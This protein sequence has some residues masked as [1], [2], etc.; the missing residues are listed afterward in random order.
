MSKIVKLYIFIFVL[1]VVAMLYGE[2]VKKKTINWFPSY[3]KKHKIPYGTYVLYHSLKD[4]FPDTKIKNISQTPYLFLKEEEQTG[5]YLFIDVGINIDKETQYKLLD[6]VERGNSVFFSTRGFIIDTLGIKTKTIRP[7]G[8]DDT[9]FFKLYSPSFK[10]KEYT[11]DR[12]FSNIVFSKIDTLKTTI[13]GQSGY[14][15]EKGERS[16]SGANFIKHQHGNGYFYFHT[17]PE[18]FTNY[19]ILNSP[20]HLYAAGVLSYLD[21]PKILFWDMYYKTGKSQISSPMHY[22]LT[23]KP[24]KWAYYIM[25]FGVLIYILFEGK[26]KQRSIPIITPLKNQ[27]LAFTRTI[28]NMYFE[29]QENKTIAE[30][31]I[32]YFLEYIRIKYRVPTY[33]LNEEFITNLAARTGKS[34]ESIKILFEKIKKIH[35]KNYVSDDE[36]IQLNKL[37]EKLKE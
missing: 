5:T 21:K 30:H 3:A 36:L 23:S 24:L 8:I 4:L 9:P 33:T 7:D 29:K 20:A 14:V 18:T 37:I 15:N 25:L 2:S 31:Q 22:I 10:N 13:L 32:Q 19:Q 26:R 35:N 34:I 16:V 11:F 28:A 17:F 6:F 12:Q 1:A 27:T